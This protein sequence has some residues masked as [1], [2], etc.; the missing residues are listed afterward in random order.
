MTDVRAPETDPFDSAGAE[1]PG[2][3]PEDPASPGGAALGLADWLKWAWRQLTSM[4]IALVLLF[5]LA[6]GSVPGSMLPQQGSNPAGV[7]QYFTSHPALAPLL[8]HL[9]LFNVFG[10][11][12]FAAI[13]LLLFA[14]LVGCVVPRTFRLAGSARTLPPR[15]PRNLA[16]LPASAEYAAALAPADAVEVAAR[17]LSGHGFRLRRPDGPDDA[18]TGS[19][20]SAEKGYLREAGNLLFH[21]ALLGVLVSVALGGLFGYKADRLL[22]QGTSFADTQSALDEFYPGRLVTAADLPPFTVTLNS[23]DASYISSGPQRGQPSSFD[24]Q[25]SYTASP[26]A[27][28]RTDR[29]EVN[30]PLSVDG[31]K[32]YL[33]GHGY[34][35]EFKV[36]DARGQ[37]VYNGAQPFISGATGNFLSEGVLKIPGAQPEQLGFSGVFVPTAIDVGGTLESVFP[38]ADNPV[39]SLIAY[40]GNLGMNTGPPQS[41]YYMDTAGMKR[42][43]TDPQV[44]QIGQSLKLPDGQG[45]ITFTGYRQWVSLTITHDPGQLP[46]LICAIAALCGLLLSF[47][48][49]RRRV[50]V[51]ARASA[52]SAGEQGSTVLVGGLTR[53][54]A[55]GAFEDE[56][57]SLAA[58]L[59]SAHQQAA[60]DHGSPPDVQAAPHRHEGE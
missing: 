3:R 26:G 25:V 2:R 15:A 34:A 5:L 55:S 59:R 52:G 1:R 60:Q 12:W 46:A 23:F 21:L 53:T 13:Y 4:R 45:T 24:A 37:V 28:V 18:G 43:T 16:R 51:R 48:V 42:L 6:L 20:L 41:V 36:T 14:S 19:W 22:I 31:A 32:V 33:I 29:I 56:F 35:P 10:A 40:A 38:A 57:A 47:V 17:V 54:D 39:V 7:V 58:E 49:R 8:N 50:F 9:G 30:R 44:L 27:P 11:P